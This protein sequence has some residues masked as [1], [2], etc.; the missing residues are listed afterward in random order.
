MTFLLK[1]R[2]EEFIT[3]YNQKLSDTVISEK[4][5]VSRKAVQRYRKSLNLPINVFQLKQQKEKILELCEQGKTDAEIAK[6]IGTQ[7]ACISNFRLR[8]NIPRNSEKHLTSNEEILVKEMFEYGF[9]QNEIA[10]YLHK[11]NKFIANYLK[12]EPLET[13]SVLESPII[14][15]EEYSILIGILLGDGNIEKKESKSATFTTAHGPKQKEYSFYILKKLKSLKPKLY[16]SMGKTIDY[17]TNKTYTSYVVRVPS[18]P[19]YDKLY[20]IFYPNEKKTIPEECFNYFTE[21]SLAFLYMDDGCKVDKSYSIA[22]MCFSKEELQKF[23]YL[24]LTK[25]NIETTIQGG[26]KLYIRLKSAKH[27]TDLIKPYVPKS[28]EYKLQNFES[29]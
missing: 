1:D 15:K 14:P 11:D 3:L 29:F 13:I 9:K 25:F 12:V 20:K 23:Q 27:F 24:L 5:G 17:R 19:L 4:L 22:T 10:Y 8:N 16:L 26:N 6:I 2:Y 18:S 7:R 28:M 21:E